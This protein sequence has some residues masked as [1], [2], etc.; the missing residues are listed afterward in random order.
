[1]AG[2]ICVAC[3]Y[4]SVWV[5]NLQ[6]HH[7]LQLLLLAD[8]RLVLHPHLLRLLLLHLLLLLKPAMQ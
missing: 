3:P 5:S 6:L 2:G 8:V 7:Q 1:M 4:P